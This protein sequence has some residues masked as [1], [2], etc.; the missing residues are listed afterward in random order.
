[1]RK[2]IGILA[3][4][5]TFLVG[6]N[7]ASASSDSHLQFRNSIRT[8][9]DIQDATAAGDPAAADLQAKLTA[10]IEADVKN[11]QQ[12]DLQ[13][14]NNLRALAIYLFSGGNPDDVERRLAL[15]TIDAATKNL[16]EGAV[17]YARGDKAKAIKRLERVDPNSLPPNLGGRVALV[18]AILTS[19]EDLKA[20]LKLLVAAR[21]LMPGTL[22]EEAAL[23]RCISFA[24]KLPDIDEL[25]RCASLYM[26]RFPQSVYWQEFED[27]FILSLIGVDYLNPAGSIANLNFILNDLAP[28]DHRKMLLS[29]A[30]AAISRGRFKL[31]VAC[32]AKALEMSR[33]GSAEMARSNLYA[34]AA[35]IAQDNFNLGKEKLEAID[36]SLLGQSDS[37]L[38]GKA[39]NMARQITSQ[40]AISK[41]Q[42]IKSLT[43]EERNAGLS[44][45]YIKLLA[46]AQSALADPQPVKLN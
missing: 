20:A 29:I 22:V 40:P 25:E 44:P 16:L 30:K 31:A 5:A 18:K 34:G 46:K 28:A 14:I 15:L 13:D 45:A 27:N 35:M 37:G 21:A 43:P 41:E 39:L 6:V 24:G 1:M 4:T 36:N 9:E 32:A 17:A 26:R 42:A 38:L 2:A 19:A 12:S 3:F 11:V 33:A 8:L 23:R 10:Q 7:G